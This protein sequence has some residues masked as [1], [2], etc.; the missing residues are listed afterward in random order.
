MKRQKVWIAFKIFMSVC[1]IV[2]YML[3]KMLLSRL[4]SGKITINLLQS[5]NENFIEYMTITN[6]LNYLGWGILLLI[7]CMFFKEIKLLFVKSSK[8]LQKAPDG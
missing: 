6:F 7:A 2:D 8:V 4:Q 5:S 3:I 1:L